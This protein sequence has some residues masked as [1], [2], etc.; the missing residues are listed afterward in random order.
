[1]AVSSSTSSSERRPGRAVA[2]WLLAALLAVSWAGLEAWLHEYF[3]EPTTLMK[4]VREYK[5]YLSGRKDNVVVFGAC[6]GVGIHK[7]TAQASWGSETAVVNLAAE[8]ST[9]MDWYF[10]FSRYMPAHR[11]LKAVVLVVAGDDLQLTSAPWSSQ[12]M[13]LLQWRDLPLLLETS[14]RTA[15]CAAELT[16]RRAS[17]VYR[18]RGFL[19]NRLWESAGVPRPGRR[20][21]EA[22]LG[23]HSSQFRGE[24]LEPVAGRRGEPEGAGAAMGWQSEE[25]WL[26][27]PDEDYFWFKQILRLGEERGVPVIL[28]PLPAD[29]RHREQHT[30]WLAT[31]TR[32]TIKG[33]LDS[34]GGEV[35][36]PGPMPELPPN[37]YESVAHFD[38]PVATPYLSRRFGELMRERFP[39]E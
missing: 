11:T 20:S 25:S 4:K 6:M 5:T 29:P 27:P 14:C 10:I 1:M 9:P 30:G 34:G 32:R 26:T 23:F 35:L 19:A 16:L 18:Y 3:E 33:I 31:K 36:D 17:R 39:P 28:Y 24:L 21:V 38:L 8:G 12:T 13:D 15:S 7:G 22:G 2:T 37:A